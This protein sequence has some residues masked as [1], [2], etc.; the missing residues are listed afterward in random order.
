MI[1]R[2]KNNLMNSS[3]NMLLK[4]YAPFRFNQILKKKLPNLPEQQHID[5]NTLLNEINLEKIKIEQSELTKQFINE[6]T[7]PIGALAWIPFSSLFIASHRV[8]LKNSNNMNKEFERK[9]YKVLKETFFEA[10]GTYTADSIRKQ[11]RSIN[12][13]NPV[14]EVYNLVKD[15]GNSFQGWN[16]TTEIIEEDN[17]I[18]QERSNSNNASSKRLAEEKTV[19]LKAHYCVLNHFFKIH[20]ANKILPIICSFDE[21]WMKEMEGVG[22]KFKRTKTLSLDNEY[23]EF[24]F[25][26]GYNKSIDA[27]TEFVK[28][29]INEA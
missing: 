19:S 21:F 15:S 27:T 14:P 10:S 4:Y 12:K 26:K 6:Q 22:M 3:M 8:L 13:Q 18:T 2:L 28:K 20:Q 17:V 7:N 24:N 5:V 23:C 25:S 1:K 29:E 11:L 9:I 16:M